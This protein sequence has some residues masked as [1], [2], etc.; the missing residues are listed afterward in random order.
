MDS[1][2]KEGI[3][4]GQRTV[5]G[6]FLVGAKEGIFRPRTI[7]R[8][9]AETRWKEGLL[10]V[11]GLPWK[12]NLAHEAGEEVMLDVQAPE[13][14][15]KPEGV[16]LPPMEIAERV[17]EIRMFYVKVRDVDPAE[18]GIGFTDGCKGCIAITMGKQKT[19]HGENCRLR[20]IE[21]SSSKPEVAAR[22]K[23]S[24]ARETEWHAKKLEEEATKKSAK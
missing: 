19:A 1:A 5:S 9:P 21:K 8:V 18:G 4:L 14:S 17:K 16:P 3:Y 24:R 13:P 11:T 20:V 6:E 23:E 2:F 15:F 7:H 10:L 22:V 12:H